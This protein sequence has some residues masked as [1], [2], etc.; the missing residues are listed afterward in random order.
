MQE[1]QKKNIK[2]RKGKR[3]LEHLLLA[4]QPGLAYEKRNCGKMM[5][6]FNQLSQNFF[7]AT[8]NFK[9]DLEDDI[10]QPNHFILV[11]KNKIFKRILF[12]ASPF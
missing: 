5:G 6:D 2:P 12:I 9:F 8:Q 1:K 7:I 10:L 11:Y 4:A 3:F